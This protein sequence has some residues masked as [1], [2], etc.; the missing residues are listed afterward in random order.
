MW[1]DDIDRRGVGP[2]WVLVLVALLVLL[3]TGGVNVGNE[4]I[5]GEEQ[6]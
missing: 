4:L 5:I 2:R 6:T 3:Q 1:V